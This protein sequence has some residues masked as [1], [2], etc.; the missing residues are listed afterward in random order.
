ML[1]TAVL[2]VIFGGLSFVYTAHGPFN[3]FP[4]GEPSVTAQ[5]QA[6]ATL[7]RGAMK[8]G[9]TL[10]NISSEP[11]HF[12][13]KFDD[14]EYIKLRRRIADELQKVRE[15]EPSERL[16]PVHADVILFLEKAQ[17]T[18]QLM[19]RYSYSL[20]IDTFNRAAEASSEATR[21]MNRVTAELNRITS[22]LKAKAG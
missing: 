8:D 20:D 13:D 10:L 21:A 16:R 17:D 11:P 9:A 1:L 14:P 15:A 4:K 6:Y 12:R 22:R 19:S 18:A 5:E 3:P 2:S 7:A